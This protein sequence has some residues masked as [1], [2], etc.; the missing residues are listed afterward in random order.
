M[1]GHEYE[2]SFPFSVFQTWRIQ[3]SR[4]Q[5]AVYRCFKEL[6]QNIDHGFF[7]SLLPMVGVHR[8]V[9]RSRSLSSARARIRRRGTRNSR[10]RTGLRKWAFIGS[11]G[12]LVLLSRTSCRSRRLLST[13]TVQ[14]SSQVPLHGRPPGSVLEHQLSFDY[15]PTRCSLRQRSL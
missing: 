4:V 8:S 9:G 5:Q 12:G 11:G 10:T 3:T 2:R 14:A 15:S 6:H 7:P 1:V 13:H